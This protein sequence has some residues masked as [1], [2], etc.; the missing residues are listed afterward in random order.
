M[1]IDLSPAGPPSAY[2]AHGPRFWPWLGI[3]F[4][5]NAVGAT[6]VVLLWPAG[7]PT[8]G[9]EFWFWVFG[10]PN[11][12]FVMLLGLDRAGYE[13]H[14]LRAHYR[15]IHRRN[16]LDDKVREAQQPL[17]VL[18][19]GYSV[20]L[21]D[22]SLA[23]AIESGKSVM[24]VQRPRRGPGTILHTRFA[25][26][27]TQ[28]DDP[29]DVRP[30]ENNGEADRQPAP[31]PQQVATIA[32]K[33]AQALEPLVPSLR[34]LTAYDPVHWP[35]ARVLAEPG[36]E[37]SHVQHVR[38]ALRVAGLP[39]LACHA[40]CA[41]DGLLVADAW[42]DAREHRPLLV[43]AATWHDAKPPA[44]SC[45]ACVA[46]LLD[47]GFY[48]LPAPV[49]VIGLLHRPV[50]GELSALGDLFANASIWG[51]VAGADVKRAWITGLDSEHDT[52]LVAAFREASL[53][54]IAKQDAQR[55][56]DRIVG[57][58]AAVNSWLSM[59]ASL[60]SG[61]PGPH[62]IV[63]RAQAAILHVY[64]QHSTLESTYDASD[65]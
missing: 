64:P 6:I 11:S 60:G 35:E 8:R 29:S 31:Q 27:E 49:N 50:A 12:V 52:A 14:W 48:R 54:A 19:I 4:F 18:G 58:A 53:S 43:I 23:E 40:V 41:A 38:D 21:G 32:L 65:A 26:D 30:D 3:W 57:D 13:T 17:R 51:N 15:N 36:E 62:L 24:K 55:R 63:D 28:T 59:A 25:E 9:L 61:E 5:T 47:S 10:M 33:I 1:P 56:P 34:A 44:N 42:L 37:A 45:E 16:W 46:V 7:T 20:P 39:P 2:P 22:Q